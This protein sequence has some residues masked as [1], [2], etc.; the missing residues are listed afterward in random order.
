MIRIQKY[1]IVLILFIT[2]TI[3]S[4]GQSKQTKMDEFISNLLKKMTLQEKLGQ[5][6]LSSGNLGAVL[7]GGD[8]QSEAI[9]K[10]EIGATGGFSF[11][12]IKKTQDAAMESRLKI[13]VLIGLD[14]IHGYKTIFPIRLRLS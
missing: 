11:D 5:I 2:L 7:G 4:F 12:A 1:Q 13:P 8:G 9:K 3:S 14:V 6:N 10:G